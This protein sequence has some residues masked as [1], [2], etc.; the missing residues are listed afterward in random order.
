[1]FALPLATLSGVLATGALAATGIGQATKFRARFSTSRAGAASGLRLQTA[2]RLP[3]TGITE[4]PAVRETLVLPAGTR[5]RLAA[6]PQCRA[7]DAMLAAA[8]A[9]AACPKRSRVGDGSA[10]GVLGGMAVHFGIGIYAVRGSLVFAAERDR[11]PLKQYFVG[12]SEGTRLVLTVPTLGGRIAPTAFAVRIAARAAAGGWLRTPVTCPPS[13]HWT[14]T[15]Y[16]QGVSSAAANA[17]PV[18]PAQKLVDRI[19]CR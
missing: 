10:D 3:Q 11:Q 4:P 8:G 14:A 19:P 1:M 17:H 9:E 6:L 16:F 18:T 15:G 7:S 5:I 12:V 2:G 13:G